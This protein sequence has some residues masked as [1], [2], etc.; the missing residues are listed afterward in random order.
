MLSQSWLKLTV[1]CGAVLAA[2][3]SFAAFALPM[4]DEKDSKAKE[5]KPVE[6]RLR[7]ALPA[8]LS[9]ETRERIIKIVADAKEKKE[10]E[11]RVDG[12]ASGEGEVKILSFGKGMVMDDLGNISTII[13]DGADI[14]TDGKGLDKLPQELKVKVEGILERVQEKAK[15]KDATIVEIESD[16]DEK[17]LGNITIGAKSSGRF[18]VIGADGKEQTFRFGDGESA[19]MEDAIAKMPTEIAEKLKSV[20]IVADKE[21]GK[22]MESLKGRTQFRVIR[23]ENVERKTGGLEG[24]LDAILSRLEA[25][26]EKVNALQKD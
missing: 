16:F 25:L 23:A 24:K 7:A 14:E 18:V 15:D 22:A 3:S 11:V 20:Q 13:L 1:F 19:T 2:S 17:K 12:A 9:E 5:K 6:I 10:I 26:E 21:L 4:D 8:E